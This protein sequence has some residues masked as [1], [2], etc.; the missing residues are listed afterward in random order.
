[1]EWRSSDRRAR[2]SRN[3]YMRSL[4]LAHHEIVRRMYLDYLEDSECRL[5]GQIWLRML[6]ER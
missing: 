5:L 2:S 4:A 6:A 3:V 1:M